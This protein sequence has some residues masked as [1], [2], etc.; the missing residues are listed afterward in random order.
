MQPGER[1]HDDDDN[2]LQLKK[3]QSTDNGVPF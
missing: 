2:S 1:Y 3:Q